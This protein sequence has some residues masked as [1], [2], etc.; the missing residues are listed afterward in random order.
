MKPLNIWCLLIPIIVALEE[1]NKKIR[2]ESEEYSTS[3]GWLHWSYLLNLDASNPDGARDV[4]VKV[5][6]FPTNSCMKMYSSDYKNCIGSYKYQC[7]GEKMLP[8]FYI[9]CKLLIFKI[10]N[11]CMF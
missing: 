3:I 2:V 1:L 10:T 7:S 11:K 4:V 5:T 9:P 6:G 8:I